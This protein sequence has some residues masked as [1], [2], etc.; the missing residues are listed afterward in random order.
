[1]CVCDTSQQ[2]GHSLRTFK[3][4]WFKSRCASEARTT[5]TT[6]LRSGSHPQTFFGAGAQTRNGLSG[7]TGGSTGPHLHFEIRDEKS[8][9]PLYPLLFYKIKDQVSPQ[10][11]AI[12][13]YSLADTTVPKLS[14]VFP[15]H[16]GYGDTCALHESSI[17][18]NESI[19]GLAFA[20]FDKVQPGG[21]PNNIYAVKLWYDDFL[22]YSHQLNQIDFSE[23]R[24]IN[25]FSE[26]YG[27]YRFQ[28]CFLPTLYPNKFLHKEFN[29]GRLVLRDNDFHKMRFQFSDEWLSHLPP[30]LFAYR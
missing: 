3:F 5:G 7:N 29:K 22:I 6:K 15:V 30:I 4:I 23:T 24:Y 8:E 19:V 10:V 2:P 1:M 12:A 17:T 14:R 26:S 21:S 25:E 20:G 9:T 13:L 28:K 18:L 27:G 11:Q 16:A